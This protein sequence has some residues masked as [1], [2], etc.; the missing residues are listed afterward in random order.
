MMRKETAKPEVTQKLDLEVEVCP[1]S[2]IKSR[3]ALEAL[4]PGEI[5]EVTLGNSESAANVPRTLDLEGHD[6]ISVDKSGPGIWS[7]I[8]QRA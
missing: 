4:A 8:I 1:F 7:V 5:L 2:L 6:V 3:I